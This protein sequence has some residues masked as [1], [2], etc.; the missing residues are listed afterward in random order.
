MDSGYPPTS[1]GGIDTSPEKEPRVLWGEVGPEHWEGHLPLPEPE[2]ELLLT[3]R[4]GEGKRY[5][6]QIEKV[7]LTGAVP[8]EILQRF[9]PELLPFLLFETIQEC[10]DR[11]LQLASPET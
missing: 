5:L 9:Y 4:L 2:F 8:S 1:F 10:S 7:D 11:A 6:A 3:V